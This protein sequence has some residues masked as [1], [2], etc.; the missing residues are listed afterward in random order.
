MYWLWWYTRGASRIFRDF[1][2]FG[3]GTFGGGLT[4]FVGVSAAAEKAAFVHGSSGN[5][6]VKPTVANYTIVAL[7]GFISK[8]GLYFF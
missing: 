4:S 6:S 7:V 5:G 3:G 2:F 8:K 1:I